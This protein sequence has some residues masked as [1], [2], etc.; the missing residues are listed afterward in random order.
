MFKKF[1]NY[2]S[3]NTG[4]L[5]RFDDIAENMR[6][7]LMNEIE[8]LFDKFEIKP[9]LGV[10]PYNRDKELLSYPKIEEDFWQKVRSWKKKG[11]EIGMHGTHHVYDKFCSKNDFLK[12]GGN[13][14]FCD[15]TFEDQFEKISLGVKKF[16]EEK[17]NVRTFFAP[18]HTF[19]QNTLSALK[20]CGINEILDGYGIMPYE[21]NNIKF[22]P[23][24][25][26]RLRKLPFGIQSFQI[27][28]NYLNNKEFDNLK[29]FIIKNSKKIITYDKALSKINNSIFYE[30]MRLVTKKV[31]QIKRLG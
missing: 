14:E 24:L 1:T 28:L 23:Q 8:I 6:W 16:K 3:D 12:H 22:I 25:F 2:L 5:L 11:W 9:V 27:H 4:F 30:M 10:I 7:D 19:D 29:S 13:T 17:I 31:L 21:K 15:H 20:K 18:N 26:Y